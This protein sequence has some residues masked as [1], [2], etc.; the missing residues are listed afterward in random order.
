MRDIDNTRL[1]NIRNTPGER[2]SRI[3]PRI[4]CV[5]ATNLKRET[6]VT[7]R[8]RETILIYPQSSILV[9]RLARDVKRLETNLFKSSNFYQI[10]GY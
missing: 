5:Y 8:D 1:I 3:F 2:T 10:D 4:P 9:K 7:R 6:D